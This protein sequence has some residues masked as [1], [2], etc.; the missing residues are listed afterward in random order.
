VEKALRVL[1]A[2]AQTRSGLAR[3]LHRAGYGPVAVETACDRVEALGYVD[4]R[5]FAE[6]ALR[7]R[8]QQG[9]GLKVIGAELRHKGIDPELIDEVLGEVNL[10]DEVQRAAELAVKL[11]QRHQGEP[12]VRRRERVLGTLVRRGYTPWVA[13]KA[14]ETSPA[15]DS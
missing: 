13:R 3:K 5:A 1:N 9:R 2:A 12:V 15:L 8:Q 4:D 11:L 7:R 6:A 14:L 10:E